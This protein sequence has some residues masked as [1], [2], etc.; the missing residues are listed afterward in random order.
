MRLSQAAGWRLLAWQQEC[1]SDQDLGPRRPVG[2]AGGFPK[3]AL[4]SSWAPSLPTLTWAPGQLDQRL[5]GDTSDLGTH[6]FPGGGE[7]WANGVRPREQV[8]I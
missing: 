4:S 7:G 3:S 6:P 1:T 5:M 8:G 2:K